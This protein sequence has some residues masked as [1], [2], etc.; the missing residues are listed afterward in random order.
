[1]EEKSEADELVGDVWTCGLSCLIT[2]Q[3]LVSPDVLQEQLLQ[4]LFRRFPLMSFS[5]LIQFSRPSICS[6]L[7]TTKHLPEVELLQ[8]N[9]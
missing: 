7:I 2:K 9:L 5:Q 1:M 4:K 3:H 6:R 8:I